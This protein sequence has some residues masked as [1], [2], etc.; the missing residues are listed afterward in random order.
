[1]VVQITSPSSL[2]D[3]EDARDYTSPDHLL[4]SR[5]PPSGPMAAP[6]QGWAGGAFSLFQNCFAARPEWSGLKERKHL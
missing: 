5:G 6:E 2:K 4:C 1:M 3:D